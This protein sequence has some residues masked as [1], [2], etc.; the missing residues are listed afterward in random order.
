M[1]A[2]VIGATGATG[3]D[4]V[5]QLCQD[6][7][8]DEIDIFVRRRSDFHHEKVKAHLVD[9]DHPEEWKHLVKGDV[10]FSCLGTTLKSA[11]SKEN[12]K[13]IDYDYQFNFAKAAK[14]NNVQDYI[15]VSA[16]GASPDS[17][18]FYSRI[19]GELE[20][21]VKNLKFEKTTIFKPGMLER[22]N[23]DRN[24]E[25]F[26][27]KIIKFLNKFGLFKSQQ[28]LPTEVLAKAMIVASKIKS[29][30]FSEVKLHSIFSF[31]EK[32]AQ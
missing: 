5:K 27:L 20:E 13:V 26:G 22:K 25:V 1:K 4:L 16:Y 2:L 24:G 6:S 14:E 31:A 3:K 30:S 8:F 12:Q 11:G 19:K 10:A 15:L 7:D 21:A 18:I 9:F 23:T 28:P 17:K 29:N 32:K